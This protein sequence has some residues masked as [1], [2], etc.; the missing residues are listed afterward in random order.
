MTRIWA[1]IYDASGNRV[2]DGPLTNI[3]GARVTRVLDGP[4]EVSISLPLGDPR[5]QDL[6]AN[7][8]RIKI[9][10]W[11][12]GAVQSGSSYHYVGGT[13]R[14]VGVG[15]LRKLRAEES[16][17]GWT[18][19]PTGPDQLNE[20]A[21]V[22]TLLARIYDGSTISSVVS[23]LIALASGWSVDT[24]GLL[25]DETIY[26][27]F[28]GTS[29]LKSL[30]EIA[31][32]QGLHL[33]L[34]GDQHIKLGP[35]GDAAP[36][37]IIQSGH[38]LMRSMMENDDVAVIQRLTWVDDSEAVANWIIPVGGGQ[39]EA[40]LTLQ[41]STRGQ[42]RT[43]VLEQYASGQDQN[44][45]L[46][47]TGG[48]PLKEKLAQSFQLDA[49]S[50]VK[51]AQLYLR[52]TGSPT[53]TLTLRIE[54]DS[55]GSPSGTLA[56]AN[57]TTTLAESS[58]ETT[59]YAFEQ[60]V[61]STGF[62]LDASTTYWLVLSTTRSGS[63]TNF[64]LWGAD[65]T[66]PTYADGQM[67]YYASSAWSA[68]SK[69]ALFKVETQLDS[70]ASR[71]L[72]QY[73]IENRDKVLPLQ[74]S[75][76]LQQADTVTGCTYSANYGTPDPLWDGNASTY[77]TS[78]FIGTSHNA[79][80]LPASVTVVSFS[81]RAR[82]DD[83][84]R[85]PKR[86]YLKRWTGVTWNTE[87][88]VTAAPAWTAGEKRTYTLPSPVSGDYWRLEVAETQN[89]LGAQV[90]DVELF[91]YAAAAAKLAQSFLVPSGGARI[92]E[93]ALWLAKKG[94]PTGNL[95]VTIETN[96][97]GAPSGTAVTNGD[98]TSGTVAASGLTA[99]T[100]RTAFTFTNPPFLAAGTYWA[101]L[102]TTD[103]A[104]ATD[105]VFLA[106]DGSSPAYADGELKTYDGSSWNAAS[107]DAIFDVLAEC[108]VEPYQIQTTTGPDGRTLYYLSHS[109]SITAYGQIEKVFSASI[110]PVGNSRQDLI[111]AANALYDAAAAWLDRYAVKQ[112]TYSCTINKAVSTIKPGMLVPL[113]YK[114]F[115]YDRDGNKVSW[116]DTNTTFWVVRV[117]EDLV[118]GAVTLDIS[119]VDRVQEDMSNLIVGTME[120]VTLKNVQVQPYPA[121]F[122]DTTVE[123]SYTALTYIRNGTNVS[124]F[125]RAN[126]ILEPNDAI[127]A[128]SRIVLR[129]RS[130]PLYT[131]AWYDNIAA[132]AE[133]DVV[134]IFTV[135]E[136]DR[137]PASIDIYINDVVK[138]SSLTGLKSGTTGPWLTGSNQNE[139]F[140][141]YFDITDL[142]LDG[143]SNIYS[144][145]T[146][147]VQAG[148]RN[149]STPVTL[150]I[151]SFAGTL[152][153]TIEPTGGLFKITFEVHC[154]TQA[155]K[156]D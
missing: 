54:T 38:R 86:F 78:P 43:V 18:L 116:L 87:Y 133:A 27:R 99:Q 112:T 125:R 26:A 14:D 126:A 147:G 72:A 12:P 51:S 104:D 33:R 22:N 55:G 42:D 10:R 20:L 113:V 105:F 151:P 62:Y 91:V 127:L 144:D 40:A 8:R 30:Q 32:R 88:S 56:H 60:F 39:G 89:G 131:M 145:V 50:W 142:L 44:A 74:Y 94:S 58:L 117:S 71:Y 37:R 148:F 2:G 75:G 155:V 66:S 149:I 97:G 17:N 92:S 110:S 82:H 5:V 11:E 52:K 140:D 1:D 84:S 150:A 45:A 29:V 53:G 4:G 134:G 98:G 61:F 103:S 132:A 152:N 111:N 102:E 135:V 93:I 100:A 114:G 67:K 96:S 101:V 35:L 13:Q 23:S 77:W 136:D 28:D 115:I 64:V 16:E 109:D 46:Q 107:A 63:G 80:L 119:D 154:V 156:V 25:N 81:V 120:A 83:A 139:E 70:R 57:A 9:W 128:V 15:I 24:S 146:V 48:G 6:V 95:T 36:V 141:E 76:A 31:K 108:I 118:T 7:E 21:R 138:S 49:D 85:A 106:A 124:M 65:A 34:D 137:Y 90:A 143:E 121:V 68:E 69:D 41:H 3:L 130:Y 47:Y 73:G 59:A 122:R 79:I 129:V 153:T 19:Q 123:P